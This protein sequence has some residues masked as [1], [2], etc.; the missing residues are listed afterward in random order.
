MSISVESVP[1]ESLGRP[2]RGPQALTDDWGTEVLTDDAA[3]V[4]AVRVDPIG[5]HL[6]REQLQRRIE[7]S[8]GEVARIAIAE[9]DDIFHRWCSKGT[10]PPT[11]R[12]RS[13]L[14]TLLRAVAMC[15]GTWFWTAN[16]VALR[17]RGGVAAP[18]VAVAN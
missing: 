14:Q 5:S 6:G 8:M 18:D 11:S 3:R 7:F 9:E 1:Y 10:R 16:S 17:A 12:K 15:R 13:V 4:W 2:I